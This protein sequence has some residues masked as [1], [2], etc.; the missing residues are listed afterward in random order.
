MISKKIDKDGQHF[1]CTNKIVVKKIEINKYANDIS[2]TSEV[3][4][5]CWMVALCLCKFVNI[6][7]LSKNAFHAN[8]MDDVRM[9]TFLLRFHTATISASFCRRISTVMNEIFSFNACK[10]YLFTH[11][12]SSCLKDALC[13]SSSVLHHTSITFMRRSVWYACIIQWEGKGTSL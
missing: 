12:I 5:Q 9:F 13:L 3:V 4:N 11:I 6:I 7:I 2:R 1:P 8:M 10:L